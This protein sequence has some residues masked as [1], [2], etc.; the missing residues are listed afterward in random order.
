MK[1]HFRSQ[2]VF[3][4]PLG[5][6]DAENG[7]IRGVTIARLGPAKG[8]DG[9]LDKTFL[10][11]LV[12]MAALRTQGIKARF[13]HPNACSTALGTYL[14]RF[15][16]YAYQADRVTADLHLDASAKIS[17]NGNLYDYV[18]NMATNNP[19]MFGAS[20]VF[21]SSDFEIKEADG[22]AKKQKFFRLKELLATDIVDDPAAADGLFS[23]ETMPGLATTFLDE[24]P[25]IAE[26]IFSKPQN[27]IEFLTNYL[28]NSNMN[29][30]DKLKSNF[31]KIFNLETNTP[32]PEPE[33]PVS[34]DIQIELLIDQKFDAFKPFMNIPEV[35]HN[36]AGEYIF[37]SDGNQILLNSLMKLEAIMLTAE[38]NQ[39]ELSAANAQIRVLNEKLAA[40]PTL[41]NQVTDPQVS[42]N[43]NSS[44]K[45]ETGKHILQSL[46]LDLRYRLSRSK[47]QP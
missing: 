28:N 4:A 20:I 19:D 7:I 21:Q 47:T 11:Q 24:N 32:S 36:E 46:P 41:P 44:E 6:I 25:E 22:T 10:L 16:N 39:L 17:P 38:A 8:H 23:S 31:H 26:L 43:I 33:K 13:G 15:H 1:T 29:L 37:N 42:T 3:N 40:R 45:D 12:E 35:T 5:L 27:V 14:G 9:M 34:T 18:I 2:P 30:T